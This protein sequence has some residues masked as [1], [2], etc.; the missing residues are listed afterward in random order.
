MSNDRPDFAVEPLR[1]SVLDVFER[2]G[3][4]GP[5]SYARGTGGDEAVFVLST[6]DASA[7]R[8]HPPDVVLAQLNS[9]SHRCQ[10]VIVILS[11]PKSR[12]NA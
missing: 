10:A 3:A 6:S 7:M 9:V 1:S 12:R 2:H 11:A 4:S 8:S 5:V